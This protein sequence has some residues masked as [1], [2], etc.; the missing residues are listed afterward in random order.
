MPE[1]WSVLDTL[2][3]GTN[4]CSGCS[5]TN[6]SSGAL[7]TLTTPVTA[8][9]LLQVVYTLDAITSGSN[10]DWVPH[11][12]L[13]YDAIIHHRVLSNN[14]DLITSNVRNIT[15]QTN[16]LP[17][18]MVYTSLFNIDTGIIYGWQ[19]TV[20]NNGQIILDENTRV[21]NLVVDE[22]QI[23]D[24][25]NQISVNHSIAK[26]VS[27]YLAIDVNHTGTNYAT[28][29]NFSGNTIILDTP[30][31]SKTAVIV[32]YNRY[33]IQNYRDFNID[34]FVKTGDEDLRFTMEFQLNADFIK[35]N[36]AKY[37]QISWGQLANDNISLVA[38]A[39]DIAKAAGIKTKLIIV[40]KGAIYGQ[41]GSV[42]AQ[43]FY[44]GQYY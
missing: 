24:D 31:P 35:Y 30:L 16:M 10:I 29:N 44:G 28:T 25:V 3:T 9:D 8:G 42:Y 20:D 32:N 5:F 26:V 34:N 18:Y 37:S 12:F 19:N 11:G 39:I 23:A 17:G 40:S 4:Y 43:V 1:C 22:Y 13:G 15:I 6:N 7:I 2:H 38:E 21:D 33:P 27:V 41:V 14:Y 36:T